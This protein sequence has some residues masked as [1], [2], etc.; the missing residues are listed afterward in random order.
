MKYVKRLIYW[1]KGYKRIKDGEISPSGKTFIM[2]F[3]TGDNYVSK[4]PK[5]A[6]NA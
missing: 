1:L 5:E 2:D 6:D 3:S 4:K